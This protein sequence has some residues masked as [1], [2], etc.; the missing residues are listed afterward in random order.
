MFHPLTRSVL[1]L[2]AL[3]VASATAALARAAEPPSPYG[4]VPSERQLR[5]HGLEV[6]GFLHFT[7]NTFT[8]K[9]W[10]YGDESPGIFNPTAFDADQI[11]GRGEGGRPEGPH[12]H[13]Q[14][15]RRLL[16]VALEA[17]RALRE[18]QPLARR[19]G[20]RGPG[21]RRRVPAARA[22][23]RR[24]PLALGPQ[25]PGV[26][27]AGLRRVLPRPAPGAADGLRPALRGLVRRRQRRRRLLRRRAGEA[28]DRPPDVLRLGRHAERSSASCRPAP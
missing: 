24:L 8:D 28:H 3:L 7:V 19:Q 27:P 10:G 26:R 13:R 20:R 1:A 25:P 17:H 23:L 2:S 4:P 15:P 11:V 18:E 22:R 14:A 12:P 5:W 6:Y 16:P 21:D 9:E